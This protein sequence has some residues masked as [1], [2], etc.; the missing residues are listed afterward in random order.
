[1]SEPTP[2]K[3]LPHLRFLDTVLYTIVMTV[4]LRWLPVAAAVGP[5]SLPLWVLAFVTFFIPLA[6]ATTELTAQ[7]PGEGGIYTWV[8]DSYGPLAGFVCSWF[9]WVSLL[10]YFAGIV[11]FISGVILTAFGVAGKDAT[12][13]LSLSITLACFVTVFQFA[14]LRGNKWLTNFGAAGSW[15]IFFALIALAVVLLVRGETAG[16]FHNASW[17]PK[18]NFSSAILWGTVIFA[19]CGVESVAFLR[20]EIKGGVRTIARVL[21]AVGLSQT[22]IYGVGTAAMLLL[23]PTAA[24]TRLTGLPDAVRAAF[25]HAGYGAFAVVAIGL[26]GLSQLG[27]FTAWFGIGTRLT[28][29]AASDGS[30]PKIFARRHPVTGAPGP[31]IILL[32]TLTL[33]MVFISQAGAGAAAAY[34]FL[35][36]MSVLT[37]V[38]PYVF[39][40][41][42]YLKRVPV[43]RAPG[44]W[45][46]PGGAGLRRLIG[47]VG[48][49]STLIAIACTLVP[50]SGDAHPLTTFLKIVLSALAAA[51]V[52]L[53]FYW[54]GRHRRSV[55]PALP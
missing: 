41:A 25:D 10:P 11:Y 13:Y 3:P 6:V 4:G 16:N 45:V 43:A 14:G 17:L 40:F 37:V 39:M 32:G 12:L 55:A 49:V 31:A 28:F 15:V 26:L 48:L 46:A 7:Y 30:L 23:L 19:F 34:D 50:D 51:A 54:A 33:L 24:L 53:F 18:A 38:I 20:D 36:S 52:G 44:V 1:M 35:V 9:Y 42:A 5:A 8:V 27:G 21:A 22:L 2:V 29:A 47:Y